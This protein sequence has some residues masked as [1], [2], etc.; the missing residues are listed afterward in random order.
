[1]SSNKSSKKSSHRSTGMRY[2]VEAQQEDL[3]LSQMEEVFNPWPVDKFKRDLGEDI[4]VRICEGGNPTGLSFFAQCKSV[5]DAKKLFR[6]R[7]PQELRYPIDVSHLLQWEKSH[8]PVVLILWDVLTRTGWWND[9]PALIADLD[10]RNRTWRQE[11][12]VTVSVPKA[13]VLS[14]QGRAKLRKR[15]A[16]LVTANENVK[17]I[18]GYRFPNTPEAKAALEGFRNAIEHGDPHRVDA[19]YITSFEMSEPA[20]WALDDGD[21]NALPQF[22]SLE[23][24]PKTKSICCT[25]EAIGTE[26]SERVNVALQ[27]IRSGSHSTTL[28][29]GD[30][31]GTLI[32]VT[33]VLHHPPK[34]Q[35]ARS[36]QLSYEFPGNGIQETLE[37]ARFLLV[38][39]QAGR[40]RFLGP[41]REEL[42]PL[43]PWTGN[44]HFC[45][46]HLSVWESALVRLNYVQSRV[47]HFGT[48]NVATLC[49]SDLRTLHTIH[50][51]LSTGQSNGT[52]SV[53]FKRHELLRDTSPTDISVR[54]LGS[55]WEL[56]GVTIPQGRIEAH[57]IDD[58][59]KRSMDDHFDHAERNDI[60]LQD[61]P[62]KITFLDWDPASAG[63]ASFPE[64]ADCQ[65]HEGIAT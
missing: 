41:K 22:I 53:R 52:I 18:F 51:A 16:N 35:P 7:S 34:G 27:C 17:I 54:G 42:V 10:A 39:K 43:Q 38:A 60:E 50:E 63:L 30:Q 25:L 29:N 14:G 44:D 19:E 12:E 57:F 47:Q 46:E 23:S 48:F 15:I 6:K 36:F 4:V 26:R 24:K 49:N 59:T 37:L 62:V 3:S 58:R 31:P 1:M 8:P 33:L 45:L 32:R 9:V 20:K 21:A 61:V 55:N 11:T 13:N 28:S 40:F 65:D 56:L 64:S 2:S 5:G